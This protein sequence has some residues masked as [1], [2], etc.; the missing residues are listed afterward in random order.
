MVGNSIILKVTTDAIDS[1]QCI[2]ALSM[3]MAFVG[4]VLCALWWMLLTRSIGY[5]YYYLHCARE[6]EEQ[7]LKSAVRTVSDG[8]LFGKGKPVEPDINGE[9]KPIE[10]PHTGRI[11]AK[12]TFRLFALV[13]STILALGLICNCARVLC[14]LFLR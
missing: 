6:L 12:W 9:R 5:T 7:F 1:Q 11:P 10:M 13:Y 4:L 3:V 8:E 2:P 14:T